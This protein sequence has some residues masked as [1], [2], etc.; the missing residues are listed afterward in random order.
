MLLR[1]VI[2]NRSKSQTLIKKYIVEIVSI[3]WGSINLA[4]M[5]SGIRGDINIFMIRGSVKYSG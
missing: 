1:L 2:L 3:P 5:E 4:S